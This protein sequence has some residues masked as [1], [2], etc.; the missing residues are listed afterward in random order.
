MNRRHYLA[1]VSVGLAGCTS[2]R[3]SS[4]VSTEAEPKQTSGRPDKYLNTAREHLQRAV[5][6]WMTY[7]DGKSKTFEQAVSLTTEEFTASEVL[8]HTEE[9]ESALSNAENEATT[10]QQS[11]ID[12]LRT[13]AS[14]L[15]STARVQAA[16]IQG[17]E[18]FQSMHTLLFQQSN[19]EEATTNAKDLNDLLQSVSDAV[20][21]AQETGTKLLDADSIEILEQS[22]I[23]DQYART[24]YYHGAMRKCSKSLPFVVRAVPVYREGISLYTDQQYG[25]AQQS[26]AESYELA[27]DAWNPISALDAKWTLEEEV[28]R[29]RCLMKRFGAAAKYGREAARKEGDSNLTSRANTDMQALNDCG[30]AFDPGQFP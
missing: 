1:F 19:T 6:A 7:G 20:A 12:D 23:E 29:Q 11:A 15:S 3:T 5:D 14:Y 2:K 28:E 27:T 18:Q 22:S 13:V 10:E 9:A 8:A 17:Y 26:F 16:L 21:D 4:S 24:T 25:K 30:I